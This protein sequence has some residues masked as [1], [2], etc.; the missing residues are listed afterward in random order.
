[1]ASTISVVCFQAVSVNVSNIMQPK[2]AINE[3]ILPI[4]RRRLWA[5]SF[6]IRSLTIWACD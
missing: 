4:I 1:M 6:V 5:F 3:A 2:A